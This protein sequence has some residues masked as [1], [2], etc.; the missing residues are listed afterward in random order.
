MLVQSIITPINTNPI[1]LS[2]TCFC[3]GVANE[4]CSHQ[5]FCYFLG[6]CWSD[7]CWRLFWI[8]KEQV[9]LGDPFIICIDELLHRQGLSLRDRNSWEVVTF[10]WNKNLHYFATNGDGG[11]VISRSYTWQA[12]GTLL[13]GFLAFVW[14]A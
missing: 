10:S 11:M 12:A 2:C 13:P 8:R 14:Y 9:A 5:V 7:I 3:I 1:S 4:L 6:F